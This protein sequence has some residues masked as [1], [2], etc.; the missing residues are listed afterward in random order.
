M[1][2]SKFAVWPIRKSLAALDAF[3]AG[4]HGVVFTSD[5]VVVVSSFSHTTV[6][7]IIAGGR[8]WERLDCYGN[9]RKRTPESLRR[10]AVVFAAS[11]N[12]ESKRR[13]LA[14]RV[15]S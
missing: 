14:K 15:A 13:A 6:F 5:G 4:Y 3:G 2:V 7:Q 10:Q 8:R 1:K 12:T 11:V 9:S